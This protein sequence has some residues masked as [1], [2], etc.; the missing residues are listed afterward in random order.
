MCTPFVY[1]VSFCISRETFYSS[2]S[3]YGFVNEMIL[4]LHPMKNKTSFEKSGRNMPPDFVY[5]G[6]KAQPSCISE[7]GCAKSY[8]E[9]LRLPKVYVQQNM[10]DSRSGF[11][12][13]DGLEYLPNNRTKFFCLIGAW[14][15]E[16]MPGKARVGKGWCVEI[17]HVPTLAL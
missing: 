7:A 3:R 2:D 15:L 9:Y 4:E 10:F 8:K 5:L 1:V 13:T 11:T 12:T 16:S 14:L 6:S 17:T